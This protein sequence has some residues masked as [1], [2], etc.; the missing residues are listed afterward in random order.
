MHPRKLTILAVFTAMMVTPHSQGVAQQSI[1][2]GALSEQGRAIFAAFF[3]KPDPA[4]HTCLDELKA[5]EHRLI[6]EGEKPVFSW[7]VAKVLLRKQ[8]NLKETC[9]ALARARSIKLMDQLPPADRATYFR[10]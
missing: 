9:S 3:G 4:L 2:R 1:G 10:S 5:I 6:E 8:G 7:P